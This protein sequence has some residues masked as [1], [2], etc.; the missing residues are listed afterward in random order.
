MAYDRAKALPVYRLG[1]EEY[2]GLMLRA[3]RPSFLGER[4]LRA[5]LPVLEGTARAEVKEQA[6]AAAAEAM[7]WALVDWDLEWAGRPVPPN[8]A[9]LQ[10]LDTVFLLELVR[11]WVRNVAIRPATVDSPEVV[12]T[13]VHDD[14]SLALHDI[15]TVTLPD[16]DEPLAE[17]G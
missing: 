12:A 11:A 9:G 16:P 5:A 3:R 6:L 2:P 7:G 17:A 15:P 10:S 8:A 4:A 14:A 13:P 1:F